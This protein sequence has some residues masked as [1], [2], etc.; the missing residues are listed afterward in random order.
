MAQ[1]WA[2]APMPRDQIALFSPT[3]DSAISEDH[4]VRLLDEILRALDWSAWVVPCSEHAGRPPIHPRILA[5]IIL[6]GLLQRIRSSRMLEYMCG[7]NLDFLWLAEGH[8]PDH[9]TL[10]GFRKR[11]RQALKDLF[12]QVGRLAMAMGLVRLGEVAFDGTRIKANASRY[13]TWT[14]A[15]V[16]GALAE[17]EA[18]FERMM[19]EADAA[20][21]A[22]QEGLFPA[23]SGRSLPAELASLKRRQE[24]LREVQSRRNSCGP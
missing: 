24:K 8:R 18:T 12:G 23:E 9:S 5:G 3:L 15:K 16:E 14:A 1:H 21:A 4:P 13:E 20:D 7:H 11:S 10:C 2:K 17:L 19:A 22:T 6:Y